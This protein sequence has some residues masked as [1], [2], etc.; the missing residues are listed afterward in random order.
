MCCAERQLWHSE[1][2]P[3]WLQIPVNHMKINKVE[4]LIPDKR[5]ISVCEILQVNISV[6]HLKTIIYD[7]P[8]VLKSEHTMGPKLQDEI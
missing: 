7:L 6:S 3:P 1:Q 2:S 8:S 5:Q 4:K